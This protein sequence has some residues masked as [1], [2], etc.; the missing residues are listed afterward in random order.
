M[1]LTLSVSNVDQ[2]Q[3][4]LEILAN[5]IRL[6]GPAPATKESTLAELELSTRAY[7]CLAS[8][9]ITTVEELVC[10][11]SRELLYIPNLGGRSLYEIENALRERG[12]TLG[13]KHRRTPT[14]P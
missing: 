12:L 4:A 9:G 7:N 13:M 6:H 3:Q 11:T 5:Y 14:H 10:Y 8:E 1:N 2:A